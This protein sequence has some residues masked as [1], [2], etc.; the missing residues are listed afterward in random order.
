M[1]T[2][3]RPRE[4]ASFAFAAASFCPVPRAGIDARTTVKPFR[5]G[6]A[7][8]PD[9]FGV[10]FGRR[11]G[12]RGRRGGGGRRDDRRRGRSGDERR[13]RDD[14][15]LTDGAPGVASRDDS[16]RRR[17]CRDQQEQQGREDPVPGVAPEAAFPGAADCAQAARRHEARA[18]LEA[19]LLAGLGAGSA[20]GRRSQARVPPA[21]SSA[22]SAGSASVFLI[23]GPGGGPAVRAEERVGRQGMAALGAGQ[24]GAVARRPAAVGAEV[25][26]P[27]QRRAALAASGRDATPRCRKH[28]VELVQ[29]RVQA[30]E[31]VAALG[32]QVLA[33]AV[34]PVHLEHQAAEI[35]Q[36]LVAGALD[37]APFAA[38]H[39]RRRQ[40]TARRGGMRGSAEAVE[41][42][43]ARRVYGSMGGR[44][45][46]AG[47][48]RRGTAPSGAL[49][50]RRPR[51]RPT[52][53]GRAGVP[54]ARQERVRLRS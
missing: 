21:V 28:L 44:S 48:N 5:A 45:P 33:E 14:R 27:G 38:D 2:L 8:G 50:P 43:H 42:G 37:G 31:L 22:G 53:R 3:R 30:E 47:R 35:A 13:G 17:A 39:A 23:I 32:E 52:D 49:P 29:P 46:H 10:G 15:A 20:G 11:P 16:G 40:C 54:R 1:P 26:A 19:V 36:P 24:Y 18:A 25:R 9:G 34:L 51:G 41:Q 4:I 12:V 7:I 6:Q